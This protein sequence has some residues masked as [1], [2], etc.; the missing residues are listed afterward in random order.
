MIF[1]CFV[2]SCPT[3]S[4]RGHG[5]IGQFSTREALVV[6]PDRCGHFHCADTAL[7]SLSGLSFN[8]P[9]ATTMPREVGDAVDVV[10][11]GVAIGMARENV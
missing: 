1:T 6:T 4:S 9:C 7:W 5:S 11:G 3:S 2:L 10:L 8:A